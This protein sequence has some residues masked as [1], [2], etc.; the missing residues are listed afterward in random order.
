MDVLYGSW[1]IKR[2]YGKERE[3]GNKRGR[4]EAIKIKKNKI[5]LTFRIYNSFA[6]FGFTFNN[7]MRPLCLLSSSSSI[8]GRFGFFSFFLNLTLS[9]RLFIRSHLRRVHAN[10]YLFLGKRNG[11]RA[12]ARKTPDRNEH[13][14]SL[15]K[16]GVYPWQLGIVVNPAHRYR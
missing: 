1:T 8:G 15:T 2:K 12:K 10:A 16:Y 5:T 13:S 14:H 4:K 11:E 3:R 7:R 6:P 9:R